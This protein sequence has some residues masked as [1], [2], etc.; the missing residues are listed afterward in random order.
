LFGVQKPDQIKIGNY[1][2]DPQQVVSGSGYFTHTWNGLQVKP[3]L[4]SAV[5]KK[6]SS[7]PSWA[8]MH[9]N[10]WEEEAQVEQGGFL[11]VKKQVF[12]RAV[13]NGEETWL[14]LSD[15]TQLSPGDRLMV[16]LLIETPQALDFVHVNDKRASVLEPVTLLSGYEWKS[17]LGYYVSITDAGTDFFIDHLP[18]GK[19]N[20]SYE[21]VVSHKGK[22]SS[23]PATVSCFYA[24]EFSGHSGGSFFK[25]N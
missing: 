11:E 3:S 17:G 4:G 9:W 20:L 15:T 16:R 6:Q 1:Q 21:V 22:A 18:K 23:G 12:K 8:S 10:Y 24:P 2:M 14:A 19:F 25:T 7:T 5:V 13:S